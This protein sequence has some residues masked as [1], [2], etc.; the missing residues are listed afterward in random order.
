MLNQHPGIRGSR[1]GPGR[2]TIG[3]FAPDSKC[4]RDAFRTTRNIYTRPLLER[5]ARSR[6]TGRRAA[7]A[8]YGK[9]GAEP[10]LRLEQISIA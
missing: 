3:L 5:A 7:L 9:Q 2:R 4:S 10:P 8:A 6:R 1:W